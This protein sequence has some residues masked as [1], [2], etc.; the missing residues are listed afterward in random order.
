MLGLCN[1]LLLRGLNP[2]GTRVE[3]N[4]TTGSTLLGNVGPFENNRATARKLM[5]ISSNGEEKNT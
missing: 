3:T 5:I 4:V 1:H 2:Q